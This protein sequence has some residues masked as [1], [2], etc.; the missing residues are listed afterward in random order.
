M[1]IKGETFDFHVVSRLSWKRVGT[2]YNIRGIDKNGNAANFVET[3]QI[4]KCFVV[5][6][7]FA[8]NAFTFYRQ[9]RFEEFLTS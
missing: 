7:F 6:Y 8:Y 3:E 2:R 5:L 9:E 4:I 1:N